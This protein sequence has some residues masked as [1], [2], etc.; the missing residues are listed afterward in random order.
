M[1]EAIRL[2]ICN[3]LGKEMETSG[4]ELDGGVCSATK[5]EPST[6]EDLGKFQNENFNI[7]FKNLCKIAM[8]FYLY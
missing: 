6:L 2:Y 4:D 8:F 7:F 3:K 1:K 5:P